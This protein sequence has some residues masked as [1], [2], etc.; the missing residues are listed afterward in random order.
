MNGEYLPLDNFPVYGGKPVRIEDILDSLQIH[1][2]KSN[3][4]LVQ[5]AYIYAA[6]AHQGMIRRSGEPYL[7]HPLAVAGILCDM[8]MDVPTVVAGLLHDT[9]EDTEATLEDVAKRF[10][11]DVANIVDG[12]TKI[13]QMNFSSAKERK[14]SNMRKMILAMLTDL[15]VIL[16][17]LADRLNNMRT[18]GYMPEDKQL[19]IAS[20][21]LEIYAPLASRLGIHKIQTELED[22]CLYYLEPNTYS[23]IRLNLSVG[24]LNRRAYVEEVIEYLARQVK[25]F[26]IQAQIEGRSKHIYSIWR[27]MCDQNLT[28]EQIYDLTAFRIIVDTVQ[29][30][31]GALGVIHSIFKAIPGRFKDYINLPKANGYQSLHTAVIGLRNTRMEIQIRTQNMHNYAENGVAAHWR[32]KD[33]KAISTEEAQRITA[34]RSV[35]SWQETLINPDAFLN[36]VRESLAEHESIYVFTPAGNVKELPAGACPI[37]FAYSIHTMVGHNC[38]GA[39]VN[40]AIVPL[41][42][43]LANGDTVK[44]LTTRSGAPSRDWLSYTVSPRA[45]AKIRQWFAYEERTKAIAFGHDLLEKEM[46]RAKITKARLDNP[47]VLKKLGFSTLDELNAAV[48]FGKFPVGRIL[49]ILAPEKYQTASPPP[50][51]FASI[52]PTERTTEATHGILVSNLSDVFMR[53]AKCCLPIAGEP[54]IGYITQG[55]GVSIHSAACLSLAGLDPDRFV[56]V[57]WNNQTENNFE[58][59]FQV[60]G[61]CYPG[62]F[63]EIMDLINPRVE[64]ILEAHLSDDNQEAQMLFR[65][66]VRNQAQFETIRMLIKKNPAIKHAE[67]FFPVEKTN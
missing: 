26:C 41:H 20:E 18:L 51:K 16:V 33:G 55:H 47:E 50:Q 7:N 2:P 27:K 64:N 22:L 34:L 57:S 39:K 24:Q 63:M 67:R 59:Y 40:G 37:D 9:I 44:V 14:A 42:H 62:L 3:I 58:I 21:T 13:S 45:K 4:T 11:Q 32:Y 12:V 1:H 31:Y 53:L 5:R 49:Q 52:P 36:S 38:I 65:L 25:E 29:D 35:L 19:L 48:A 56:T 6:S 8:K 43:K 17:K 23:A 10:G 60:R 30:C 66:V 28:F 61:N 15:R 54:I 46:R